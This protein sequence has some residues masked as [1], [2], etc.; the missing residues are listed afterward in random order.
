MDVDPSAWSNISTQL[1]HGAA[2]GSGFSTAW[3]AAGITAVALTAGAI[4]W[5][6]RETPAPV[7]AAPIEA[8]IPQPT[9]VVPAAPRSASDQVTLAEVAPAKAEP[10]P[11][12]KAGHKQEAPVMA[13]QQVPPTSVPKVED[14]DAPTIP[15]KSAASGNANSVPKTQPSALQ[16]NVPPAKDPEQVIVD[17]NSQT[18]GN[19]VPPTPSPI[20]HQADQPPPGPATA[21]TPDPFAQTDPFDLFIPN[22][23]TPNGDGINDKLVISAGEHLKALVRIFAKNGSLIFQTTDLSQEWDG[24]LPNGNIAEEGYYNCIVQ[25]TDLAGKP[26]VKTEVIRLY[27]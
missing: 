16:S 17:A 23:M 20:D 8:V 24:L 10:T 7:V 25:I 4:L 6:T 9:V 12:K 3:I 13:K 15:L 22:V 27:R 11:V 18:P 5:N 21:P 1:G 14:K 26:H 19:P 2:A